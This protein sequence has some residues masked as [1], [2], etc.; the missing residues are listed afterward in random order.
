MSNL[1]E[2]LVDYIYDPENPFLNFQLGNIYFDMGQT[3]S[4]VSYYLRT[5][6][7]SDNEDLMYACLLRA[8][9]CFDIQGC[10]KKSVRGLFQ[11]AISLNPIRPEGYF[12]LSRFL[13]R[14]EEYNESYLI[15]SIGEKVSLDNMDSLPVSVDYPGRWGITFEKAV[16][17]WWCGLCDESCDLFYYLRDECELDEIH[18]NSVNDN[19]NK[20]FLN[21][22]PRVNKSEENNSKNLY[23][24][25]ID[26]QK[27]TSW[28]VDNFYDDPYK[29]RDFALKQ[30]YIEGGIGRGFIGRR[31][32]EQFLFPNLKCRFE[33]IMDKKITKWK[34][35]GMNGRFQIAWSGEQLVYHCDRQQWGAML[36]LTPDA[37]YQC[38]TTLYAHKKTRARNYYEDGWD[39]SWK[40]IPGDP[41]LDGTSFE[42]VDVLGNVFNRLVIFDA[43]NIHSASEYFGTV[44]ENARLWQMFFFDCG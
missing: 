39:A 7:R 42:P 20:L 29:V 35:Y 34:E 6:E 18:R 16:S 36:Y 1:N 21:R 5:A 12:L 9:V 26:K 33:S 43:S 30:N 15:A 25:N 2:L 32:E 3:A 14:S 27:S 17:A 40:D 22:K 38:G 8:G 28:I 31:T 24:I 11:S 41:H 19:I 13:E 37:P 4:A 23:H 10:R 44:S